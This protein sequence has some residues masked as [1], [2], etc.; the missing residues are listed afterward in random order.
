[1]ENNG[2]WKKEWIIMDNECKIMEVSRR[3]MY[4]RM[5]NNGYWKKNIY[6]MMDNGRKKG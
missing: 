2:Q 1:M 3:K 6:K 5:G 4:E